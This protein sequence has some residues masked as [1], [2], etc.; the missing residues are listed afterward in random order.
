MTHLGDQRKLVKSAPQAGVLLASFAFV[1]LSM[2]ADLAYAL[3]D[4]RIGANRS[5]T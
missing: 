3:L 1:S 2:F 5:G 4:P